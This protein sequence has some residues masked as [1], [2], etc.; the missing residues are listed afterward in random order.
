MGPDDLPLRRAYELRQA[1]RLPFAERSVQVP[2]IV[3]IDLH[4]PELLS[5]FGFRQPDPG[6]FRI[7][8][9]APGDLMIVRLA[10]EWEEGIPDH[11]TGLVLGHVGEEE[12]SRDVATGPDILGRGPQGVTH[13]HPLAIVLYPRR[14]KIQRLYIWPPA[15]GQEDLLGAERLWSTG[16]L[17]VN[18]LLRAVLLH[19]EG[20]GAGM[21]VDSLGPKEGL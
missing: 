18:D 16:A 8:K 20:L 7:A 12:F 11:Q 9:G 4:L 1:H 2:E 19:S 13:D 21:D 15:G 17:S 6:Y 3:A 10:L 14:L 5:C